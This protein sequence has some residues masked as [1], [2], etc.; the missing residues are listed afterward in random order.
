LYPTGGGQDFADLIPRDAAQRE[1]SYIWIPNIK[2]Q[3]QM[4]PKEWT[5]QVI[6]NLKEETAWCC[7]RNIADKTNLML[8]YH[9]CNPNEVWDPNRDANTVIYDSR[10]LM[11]FFFFSF[12]SMFILSMQPGAM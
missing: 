10:E 6:K 5:K 2:Y 7:E 4:I 3:C 8:C 9:V 12:G 11:D 1:G